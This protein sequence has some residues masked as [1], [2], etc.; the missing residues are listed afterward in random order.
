MAKN[1]IQRGFTL[2]ELLIV[3]GIIGMLL[4]IAAPRYFGSIEK[5]KD[6]MLR[7]TLA[8][9]R[10][11]LD[12]YYGDHGRYPDTLDALVALKYLRNMP[13]D[14]VTGSRETWIVVAPDSPDKGS[15]FDIRSG[16]EG[17]ARDQTTYRDW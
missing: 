10:D 17:L 8:V 5:S 13:L 4:A 9:T 12:K 11:A 14:P 15:V 6:T 2:I 3:M 1:P 7:Q 16:A